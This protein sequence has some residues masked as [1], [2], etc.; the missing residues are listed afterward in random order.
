[1]IEILNL[2][3]I[4]V[5]LS[6]L[7]K[8]AK[9]VLREEGIE[10][11]LSLVLVESDRIKEFNK[12]YRKKDFPTDVLSFGQFDDSGFVLPVEENNQGEI[13]ICPEQVKNNAEKLGIAFEEELINILIHG[14][15]HVLG[16][17]HEGTKT[18]RVKMFNKQRYYLE[19][20]L[21]IA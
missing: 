12:K 11:K 13:V 7:K 5:R 6:F 14:I 4:I 1:M 19:K 9:T 15:L 21:K 2:T 18:K 10:G 17:S 3:E 16:Y 8:V 20:C